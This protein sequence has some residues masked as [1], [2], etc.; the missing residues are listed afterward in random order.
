MTAEFPLAP[1]LKAKVRAAMIDKVPLF[2][3]W[4]PT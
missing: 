2:R 1:M 3:G 4:Q